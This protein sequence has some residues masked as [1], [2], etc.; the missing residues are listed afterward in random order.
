[1]SLPRLTYLVIAIGAGLWCALLALPPVLAHLS[2]SPEGAPELIASMFRPI[3]HQLEGR[4]VLIFG[5]PMAVCSRCSAIYLA[6]FAGTLLYPLL[7]RLDTPVM[8]PRWVFFLALAPMVL[9]VLAGMLGFHAVTMTTRL[10]SGA[11]FG[12]VAPFIIIPAAIEGTVQLMSRANRPTV[13][14]QKGLSDA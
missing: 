9:D 7:R 2:G 12:L 1:M 4:S 8:P 6:F 10:W 13:H 11:L 14:Q 3:C 5:H